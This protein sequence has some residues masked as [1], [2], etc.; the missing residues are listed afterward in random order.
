MLSTTRLPQ[1]PCS[2][3]NRGGR[4]EVEAKG[5]AVQ[6]LTTQHLLVDS[7]YDIKR[8]YCRTTG[9]VTKQYAL[10]SFGRRVTRTDSEPG[11]EHQDFEVR[12]E[13]K[14]KLLYSIFVFVIIMLSLAIPRWLEIFQLG[15]WGTAIA[16]LVGALFTAGSVV[17]G[18]P[19][20]K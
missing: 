4:L 10:L 20:V 7:P 13:V 11:V 15:P 9:E 12:L 6:P 14:G 8:V 17:F 16:Y 19:K 5:E 2:E 18:L 3:E 1:P